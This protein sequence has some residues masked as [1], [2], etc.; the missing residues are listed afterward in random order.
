[1]IFRAKQKAGEIINLSQELAE[2]NIKDAMF[3]VIKT[4]DRRPFITPNDKYSHL[5]TFNAEKLIN[6]IDNIKK[7]DEKNSVY[8]RCLN[9]FSNLAIKKWDKKSYVYKFVYKLFHKI[10]IKNALNEI[11][12]IFNKRLETN[13]CLIQ[14]ELPLLES[15]L[16]IIYDTHYSFDNYCEFLKEADRRSYRS[17]NPLQN[18][19]EAEISDIL[20]KILTVHEVVE[21]YNLLVDR[22]T[23]NILI[24]LNRISDHF[25]IY[26][27]VIKENL[28]QAGKY[29]ELI[30][31]IN[32]NIRNQKIKRK[33]IPIIERY[34][35]YLSCN[36]NFIDKA[37]NIN[38]QEIKN[39]LS[40]VSVSTSKDLNDIELEK[41][42][43]LLELLNNCLK[44]N[45]FLNISTILI[46]TKI[47]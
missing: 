4:I 35:K 18:K 47:S 25:A 10:P 31:L 3:Y 46:K 15:A 6:T 45:F 14:E 37:K 21:R 32:A 44:G 41:I 26:D 36:T 34:V 2:F 19:N 20:N 27:K 5:K 29:P 39:I 1:M 23:K 22:N 43:E 13:R 24:I 30:S 16:K 9:V 38:F 12:T 28:N 33:L 40:K 11:N 17:Y 7:W 8:E 42:D